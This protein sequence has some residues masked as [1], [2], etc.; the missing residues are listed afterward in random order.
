MK[1]PY[2]RLMTQK[3]SDR[4]ALRR[5]MM[6]LLGIAPGPYEDEVE[7]ALRR[8]MLDCGAC[9]DDDACAKWLE[10]AD[11]TEDPPAFCPNRNLL[12]T[13]MTRR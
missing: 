2:M 6:D 10:T 8:S 9:T 4:L 11:G 7:D 13:L 5:R 12:R 1:A 3:F